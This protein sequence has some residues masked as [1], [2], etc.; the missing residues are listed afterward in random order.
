MDFSVAPL[1]RES[2]HAEAER[3]FPVVLQYFSVP[4]P[5]TRCYFLEE[6]SGTYAGV[7]NCLH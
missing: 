1:F 2:L 7:S 4:S 6:K 5:G 3:D